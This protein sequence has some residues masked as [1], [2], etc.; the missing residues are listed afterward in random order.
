VTL[1]NKITLCRIALVPLFVVLG[2]SYGQSVQAGVAEAG[3]RTAAVIVFFVIGLSDG[4]DGYIARHYHQRSRLGAVLD[5][6]ADKMLMFSSLLVLSLCAWPQPLPVWLAGVVIARDVLSSS[7]AGII[8]LVQGK[9]K[10]RPHWTGKVATVLQITV[11]SWSM[12]G[13][14]W[15][16]ARLLAALTALITVISGGVYLVEGTR[17]LLA[18]A[19]LAKTARSAV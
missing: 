12:L 16:T 17:Q 6:L 19:P 2:I 1:A 4:L 8:Y 10:I 11:V 5:P 15:G 13:F 18:P 7:A 9:V 14:H 3:I